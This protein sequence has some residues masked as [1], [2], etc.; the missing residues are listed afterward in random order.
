MSEFSDF[1][2]N[3][4]QAVLSNGIQIKITD[5]QYHGTFCSAQAWAFGC[6]GL[7][8]IYNAKP[9]KLSNFVVTKFISKEN[10]NDIFHI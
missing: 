9:Q 2:R 8:Y 10:R 4:S 5:Q 6:T 1:L 3:Q 7:K